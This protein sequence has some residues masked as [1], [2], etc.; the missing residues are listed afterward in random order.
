[1][2]RGGNKSVYEDKT[3]DATQAPTPVSAESEESSVSKTIFFILIV[4]GK[5]FQASC[6]WIQTWNTNVSPFFSALY[7]GCAFHHQN[8][9]SLSPRKRRHYFSRYEFP[10]VFVDVMIITTLYV[11][12]GC[13]IGLI[14]KLLAVSGIAN[15][16]AEEHFHPTTF[17]LIFLPPIIFE[18][19]Y[20]LHKVKIIHFSAVSCHCWV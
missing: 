7:P 10:S 2:S 4:L 14:V 17:F 9:V 20:N 19:G 1:M 13:F 11:L 18:S 16:Q 5:H 15:W 6:K 8:W 12:T 3:A